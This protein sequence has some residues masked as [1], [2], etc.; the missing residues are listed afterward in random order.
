MPRDDIARGL[1]LE[2]ALAAEEVWAMREAVA[3]MT[4][5]RDLDADSS[6]LVTEEL[7]VEA[8][9]SAI[10]PS[11]LYKVIFYSFLSLVPFHLGAP[12]FVEC[13]SSSTLAQILSKK[14][15]ERE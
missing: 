15:E 8:S 9:I 3:S 1:E 4:R 6:H 7:E 12:C 5:F 13:V 11:A 2:K 10:D 14:E